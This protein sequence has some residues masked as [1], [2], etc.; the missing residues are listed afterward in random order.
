M[1]NL[2]IKQVEHHTFSETTVIN[3]MC[4]WEAILEFGTA[5]YDDNAAT[6][7]NSKRE[8]IG[9]SEMRYLVSNILCEPIEAGWQSISDDFGDAFDWEYVPQFLKVAATYLKDQGEWTLTN[10]QGIAI[11]KSLIENKI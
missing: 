11:A 4:I 8:S 2:E 7:F 5:D 10:E 6:F 9:T 3:A 1:P